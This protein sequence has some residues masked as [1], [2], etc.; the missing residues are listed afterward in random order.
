MRTE[1]LGRTGD[2]TVKLRAQ[3][4]GNLIGEIIAESRS[5]TAELN[6][7]I[8]KKGGMGVGLEWL[9]SWMNDKHGLCVKLDMEQK[10]SPLDDDV[11]VL[12][13]ESVRELLFN[14]VKHAHTQTARVTMRQVNDGLIQI[15]I[16]DNGVGYDPSLVVLAASAS[17]FGLFSIR[18]RLDLVGGELNIKS[19]PSQGCQCTIT[20]PPAVGSTLTAAESA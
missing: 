1:V 17:G 13:F 9:A 7:P 10:E 8:L 6:P 4:I 2:A 19:S 16:T 20:M 5:L 3:E 11:K 18:E 14:V 12:V 15:V